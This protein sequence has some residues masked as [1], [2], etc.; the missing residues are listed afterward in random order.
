MHASNPET[1]HSPGSG[2][3]TQTRLIT[4]SG[5]TH[6]VPMSHRVNWWKYWIVSV[7]NHGGGS[8]LCKWFYKCVLM[9]SWKPNWWKLRVRAL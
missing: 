3:W 8:E 2:D 5:S 7:H 6:T 9:H 4:V 1:I